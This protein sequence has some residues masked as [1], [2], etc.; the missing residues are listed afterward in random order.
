MVFFPTV[1]TF[2]YL[3]RGQI[4]REQHRTSNAQI[5]QYTEIY[6]NFLTV[7]THYLNPELEITGLRTSELFRG[8]A[9]E[10]GPYYRK[11]FFPV[12][13]KINATLNC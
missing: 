1:D 13:I 5:P 3:G 2:I 12:N 11:L 10:P 4:D 7:H 8:L 9:A 6:L